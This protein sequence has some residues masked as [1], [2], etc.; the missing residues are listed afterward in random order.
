LV[1]VLAELEHNGIRVDPEVLLLQKANLAGRI[2]TLRDRIFEA[3]GVPINLDSPKQL[4]DLLFNQLKLPVI[5]KTKTG[6]S[7]DQE[8]LEKLADT[9]NLP[10]HI[11][12]AQ[13]MIP[14]LIV[15]YRQL[16]KLVNTY[17]DNLRESIRPETGR[18]HASFHQTGAATGRLSSSGPNLQ[19]I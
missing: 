16:T 12:P 18:I 19:N 10:E 6:P 5:K 4:A 13:A 15:E 17:L 11:T 1:E 9:D 2:E 8:V 7:T 3:V 14:M